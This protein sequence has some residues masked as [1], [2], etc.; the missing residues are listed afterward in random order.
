LEYTLRDRRHVLVPTALFL[1]GA[2]AAAFVFGPAIKSA[3]PNYF[4]STLQVLLGR[5]HSEETQSAIGSILDGTAAEK[6]DPT[7]LARE[8]QALYGTREN[9]P[10]WT[11]SPVAIRQAGEA[12]LRLRA[13]FEHGLDPSDYHVRELAALEP[14]TIADVAKYDL[15]LS[16]GVM[17]Y[18]RDLR[19]GR[20][21]ARAVDE[22]ILV[23]GNPD[24]ATRLAEAIN[25]GSVASFLDE[26]APS[27]PDY[28]RLKDALAR[29]RSAAASGGFPDVAANTRIALDADNQ[30][31]LRLRQRLALEDPELS[32]T[33]GTNNN[34][35]VAALRRYQGRNGLAADGRL[36]AATIRA[37]NVPASQR[38]AQIAAN[39]ERWRWLPER[40]PATRIVVNVP[41]AMLTAYRDGDA[42]I[43]S[44]VVVGAPSTPTP[45][46]ATT[47]GS[48]LVNP[49]WNV[50]TSIIRNE[51]LPQMR[52]NPNYLASQR[53][54]VMGNPQNANWSTGEGVRIQQA[55][56]AGSALGVLKFEMPNE[57]DVYLHDTPAKRAFTADARAISHGCVRVNQIMALG[58]FALTGDTKAG[59]ERINGLIGRGTQTLTLPAPIPVYILYAT[60]VPEQ[61]GAV[62][63]K[64]DVYGRDR[65]LIAAIADIR[66]PPAEL[67]TGPT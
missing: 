26:S 24:L 30:A 34:D 51:I 7:I 64:P 32:A 27:H 5:S 35:V 41:L 21:A 29:Y 44:R 56:G 48:L 66:T 54:R 52:A 23:P 65:R 50:P 3:E 60:A 37:L 15:M 38:A 55:P 46:L 58:S 62:G 45:I 63:F 4:G 47:T 36:T 59:L 2:A 6:P 16:D 49:P 1:T 11:G 12:I 17:R 43:T 57:F 40:L 10:V 42:V 61:S 18:A 22:D 53:M 8:M 13:A 67:S 25:S 28:T 19:T 39:M 14:K 31:M 9:R 33:A 20:A